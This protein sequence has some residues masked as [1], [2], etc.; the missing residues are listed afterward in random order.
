MPLTDITVKKT[1]P[2]LKAYRLADSGGLYLFVMPSGGKSWR[3]KYLVDG[4]QKLMTFGLYPDVSL[5]QA[6]ELRDAARRQKNKG[7]DPMAER[8]TVKLVRRVASENSFATV[9]KAWFTQWKGD[10]NARHADYTLRRLETNVF[11]EISARPVSD[12]QTLELVAMTK[13]TPTGVL[14]TSPSGHFRPAARSSVTR[15][16]TAWRHATQPP[17]LSQATFLFPAKKTTMPGSTLR[18]C[19]SYCVTSRLTRA[20]PLPVWR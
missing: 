6:R 10:R 1:K 12:I 18:S 13:K 20:L 3:W 11:P 4:K 5:A 14:W 15:S 9:G 7:V 17:T 2:T 8:K 19:R 16:P